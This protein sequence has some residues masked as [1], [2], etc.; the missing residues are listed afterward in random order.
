[1]LMETVIADLTN[2]IMQLETKLAR[3]EKAFRKLKKELIPENERKQRAPSGFAKPTYLSPELCTFL[4]LDPGSELARTE[5][6]KRLLQYVKDNKLQ[7][8]DNKRIIN[9]DSA[10]NILLQP[11]ET[12]PVTYFNIQRLLKN[13]YIKPSETPVV[14]VPVVEAPAV[15]STSTPKKTKPPVGKKAP[16][17]R[18]VKA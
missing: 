2:R 17:A 11:L 13:H 6:T 15:A 18:S 10:L 4:Q 7:N 5:V 9:T 3:Q 8:V 1:M 12:E 16:S 14:E